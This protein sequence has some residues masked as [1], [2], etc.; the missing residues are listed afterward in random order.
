MIGMKLEEVLELY[1]MM[2]KVDEGWVEVEED[3]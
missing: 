1:W 3:C 2:V